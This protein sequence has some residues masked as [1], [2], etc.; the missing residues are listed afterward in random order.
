[1][2][3]LPWYPPPPLLA[4]PTPPPERGGRGQQ[5]DGRQGAA[6]GPGRHGLHP[7]DC[8]RW[9]PPLLAAGSPLAL[10]GGGGGAARLLACCLRCRATLDSEPPILHPL[11]RC[12]PLAPPPNTWALILPLTHPSRCR[13][14]QGAGGGRRAHAGRRGVLPHPLSG[15]RACREDRL[16]HSTPRRASPGGLRVA[17][18]SAGSVRARAGPGRTRLTN[19]PET[20]L[21]FSDPLYP[22][23]F[24][25]ARAG[26]AQAPA[27]PRCPPLRMPPVVLPALEPEA[28]T[29]PTATCKL[30][31]FVWAAWRPPGARRVGARR[32]R[33]TSCTARG[34]PTACLAPP[35]GD[36]TAGGRGS[37]PLLPHGSQS[38][39]RFFCRTVR[40]GQGSPAD[41]AVAPAGRPPSGHHLPGI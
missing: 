16:S 24:Q 10:R 14:A 4:P 33:D 19:Q 37:V 34:R 38:F 36:G 3:A 6:G 7:G 9:A 26:A 32:G 40:R 39:T 17:A 5:R 28:A 12:S 35:D 27:P 30:A 11:A 31:S 18:R 13:S 25:R 1:M 20:T 8:R 29:L 21:C 23:V 15:A 41:E 2:P 22:S